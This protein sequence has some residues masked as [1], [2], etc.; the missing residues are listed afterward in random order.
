MSGF[1]LLWGKI[2]ESSLWVTESKETRLVWIT[3]LAMK[4]SS[5]QVF[6]SEVGLADRAKVSL[7]ECRKA[8]KVLK[9][10]DKNDTSGVEGG[11]RIRDI[12][13]GWEVVNH[14]LYRFS[15]DAK[16][17]VWRL[18]KEERRRREKIRKLRKKLSKGRPLPGEEEYV[19]AMKNGA[20][21]AE[22]DEIAA[23]IVSKNPHRDRTI[24][25]EH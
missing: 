12:T 24:A 14:D 2:L 11:R 18:D 22:L 3:L 6:A 13:G 8:L 20:S 25:G 21:D 19:K 9:A 4:N 5:G 15:T 17:E 10:P 16:R 7:D 1:A 23:R